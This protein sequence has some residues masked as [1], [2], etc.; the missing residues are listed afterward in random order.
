[1]DFD[2]LQ[3]DSTIAAQAPQGKEPPKTLPSFD[4]LEDDTGAYG[5]GGQQAI[6]GLEGAAQ[7]IAGPVAPYV[8]TKLGVSPEAIRGR[9]EAN[10]WTHGIGEAAGFVAPA[11]L[12]GGASAAARAG[13]EIPE[14]I[15]VGGKLLSKYSLPG[16]VGKAGELAQG[17]TGLGAE[18]AGVASK[19]AGAAAKYSTEMGLL[20][21]G[22]EGTK[23]ITQ[24]PDQTIGSAAANIGLSGLLGG[25]AGPAFKGAGMALGYGADKVG[26][27]Q[28]IEDFKSRMK[29]NMTGLNSEENIYDELKNHYTNVNEMADEVYGAKGLKAQ[30]QAH[31]MPEMSHTI[32]DQSQ[33]L[34]SDVQESIKRLG[35]D[36]LAR[37]LQNNLEHY[38]EVAQVGEPTSAEVFDATEKLKQQLQE[39]SKFGAFS[40]V[41]DRDFIKESKNLAYKF[42]TALEDSDVWG[43]VGERQKAINGA[44]K[45]YLPALKDFESKFTTKVGGTP[46][47]DPVK[48]RTFINQN[49]K[50][51]DKTLRQKMLGNFLDQSEKYQKALEKTHANLGLESPMQQSSLSSTKA[52]LE[53]LTPGSKAAD[54]YYKKAMSKAIGEGIGGAAGGLL[55]HPVGLGEAGAW[56]GSKM[57]GS[58]LPSFLQPLMEKTASLKGFQQAV[59]FGANVLKGESQLVKSSNN[60]FT[61]EAKTVPQHFLTNSE[62]I[63]KLNERLKDVAK[64]PAQMMN[65]AGDL[66]HYMPNHAGALAQHTMNAVNTLNAE[67]PMPKK[68]SPLDTEIKPTKDQLAM[69]HRTLALAQQPLMALQHIK[70]G[71]LLPQDVKTISSIYPAYYN[72]MSQQLMSSMADHLSKGETVPYRL[73][74]SLSMFL[75]H[76]LD[77]TMTPQALQAIQATFQE[78]QPQ[79]PQ[80]AQQGGGKPKGSA[81]KLGKVATNMQTPDQAR[82]ARANKA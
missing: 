72:K 49:G 79:Q 58:L 37:K 78:G 40:S 55:G 46:E 11:L 25:I 14:A 29:T 45:E 43:K 34:V 35:D 73:R 8:E 28:F 42:R 41:A 44:F 9:A 22:D 19:L 75:A 57:G 81:A 33:K 39:D 15:G 63:E 74:Q 67:R 70:D 64:N 32:A 77:S 71:T 31:L 16:L 12:T 23:A 13:L 80:A 48:V 36:P 17:A 6:A 21:A 4:E 59:S 1:M 10:P 38:V 5:S 69:F 65:V 18:G 52:A 20:Q 82:A 3:D 24:D 61:Q 30:E 51:T 2:S 47:V 54:L 68:L 76:P 56:I 53:E 50:A 62:D 26:A 66:D 60:I 27:K 7:G